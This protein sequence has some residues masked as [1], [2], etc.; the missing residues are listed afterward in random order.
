MKRENYVVHIV[1]TVDV[2][3]LSPYVAYSSITPLGSVR[4]IGIWFQKT[5]AKVK[6]NIMEIIL[7]IVEVFSI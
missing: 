7:G 5:S 3:G 4:K 2:K 6:I 1:L